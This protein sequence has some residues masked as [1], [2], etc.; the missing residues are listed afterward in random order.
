M[1]ESLTLG[2]YVRRLRR[3]TKT[4]LQDLADAT[5]LSISH[6]SRVENDNAMANPDTIVKLCRAL[7]GDLELMLLKADCLPQ[8]I[9][10]RLTRRAS[11][12]AAAL[13]RAT[14]DQADVGFAHA[15]VGDM[16]PQLREAIASQFGVSNND[17]DA[18]FEA[19]RQLSTMTPELR[20]IAMNA[21][22]ALAKGPAT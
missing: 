3:Q 12:G 6:L 19:L 9:L 11:Q 18:L 22:A 1:Q 13:R 17:A 2:E 7:G 14:G 10:E 20:E 8:E 21:V 5:G 4:S 15:L 16:D